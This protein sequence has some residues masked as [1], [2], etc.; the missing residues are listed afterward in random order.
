MTRSRDEFLSLGRNYG[1]HESLL[2]QQIAQRIG[3]IVESLTIEQKAA[4]NDVRSAHISGQ[5]HTIAR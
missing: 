5:G 2:G 1:R 4:L 3:D